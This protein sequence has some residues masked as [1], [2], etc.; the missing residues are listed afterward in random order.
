MRR[1]LWVALC[2]CVSVGP[3]PVCLSLCLRVHSCG[4]GYVLPHV[5]VCV[6]GGEGVVCL[7][8]CLFVCLSVCLCHEWSDAFVN[9]T[10]KALKTTSTINF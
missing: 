5:C 7:S 2:A 3:L 10:D 9:M 1:N 6:W 8:V 4:C